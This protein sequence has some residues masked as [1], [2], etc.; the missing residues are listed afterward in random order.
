MGALANDVLERQ[1]LALIGPIYDAAV[2]PDRWHEVLEQLVGVVGASVGS[3]FLQ[4]TRSAHPLEVCSYVGY[5]QPFID[6]YLE[7]YG[8]ISPWLPNA[9]QLEAGTIR[10][11]AS[12]APR[13]ELEKTEFFADWLRPQDL[14]DG[15]TGIVARDRHRNMLLTVLHSGRARLDE[16]QSVW[17]FE[18]LMPHLQRAVRV[19]QHLSH[20]NADHRALEAGLDQLRVGVIVVRENAKVIFQN[21]MAERLIRSADAFRVRRNRL[22]AATVSET[23]KL[24]DLIRSA[25]NPQGG[26]FAVATGVMTLSRTS[27]AK[28]LQLLVAPLGEQVAWP[29]GKQRSAAI[30]AVDP[31]RPAG[32]RGPTLELLYGLTPAE[33]RMAATLRNVHGDLARAAEE[34][35]IT[36]GS[37]RQYLKNVFAKTN[38]H[39][40]PELIELLSGLPSSL[41]SLNR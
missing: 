21:R 36:R 40:Q 24:H 27:D 14:V 7:H 32:L 1:A 39:R 20:L 28:P 31:E 3:L 4:E 5:E 12:F 37:A 2:D 16:K 15:V 26:R 19:G 17:L 8:K 18:F 33:A 9:T 38:T 23:G 30:F 10:T 6:Q 35:G 22:R 34:M 11:A 41:I 25:L 13:H 29:W